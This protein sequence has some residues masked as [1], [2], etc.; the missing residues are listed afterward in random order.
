M[1]L[2]R[3][4]DLAC[5]VAREFEGLRLAEYI[6]PGGYP[7]IGYGRLLSYEKKLTGHPDIDLDT[8]EEWL[9]EDMETR[10]LKAL[11]ITNAEVT[12]G[13]AAAIGDFAFNCGVSA[14]RGSSMR[15]LLEMGSPHECPRYFRMWVNAGGRQLRGL[16]RRRESEIDL[17][18]W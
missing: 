11:Y 6:C 3:A 10:L 17:W 1:N 7:T 5:E 4:C 16:V 13:Q 18:T 9:R 14:W 12:E 15:R 8:A 2:D